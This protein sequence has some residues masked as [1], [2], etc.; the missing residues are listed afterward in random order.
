L[1]DAAARAGLPDGQSALAG[2]VALFAPK[3]PRPD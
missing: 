3:S 1:R 2:A